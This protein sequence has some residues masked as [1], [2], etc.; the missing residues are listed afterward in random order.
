MEI[1]SVFDAYNLNLIL[2]AKSS[3]RAEKA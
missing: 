1:L 3:S 2:L